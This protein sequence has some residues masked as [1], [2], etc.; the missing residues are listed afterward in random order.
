M[1][2]YLIAIIGIMILILILLWSFPAT[3]TENPQNV[4][5]RMVSRLFEISTVSYTGAVDILGESNVSL[6]VNGVL[7]YADIVGTQSSINIDGHIEP[8]NL[9]EKLPLHVEFIKKNEKTYFQFNELPELGLFDTSML[10]GIW[11]E[12]AIPYKRQLGW[13]SDLTGQQRILF[14]RALQKIDVIT[15]TE[16][17][18]INKDRI[19]FGGLVNNNRLAILLEEFKK[20]RYGDDIE[21]DEISMVSDL[22]DI[23]ESLEIFFIVDENDSTLYNL[24]I[25]ISLL[26]N[27][28]NIIINLDFDKHNQEL[29]LSLPN[30]SSIKNFDI[31]DL[32]EIPLKNFEASSISD[33]EILDDE[34]YDIEL[35]FEDF[36]KNWKNK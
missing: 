21:S 10:K 3:E 22:L 19:R 28:G 25:R 6:S 29:G 13:Q 33:S 35:D 20:I 11:Y 1:K 26:E 4:F 8:S 2:K 36:K 31:F 17:E 23:I 27:K 7:S 24:E 32:I 30:S 5:N 18:S 16:F 9:S 12:L 15:Y 34:S 14:Q